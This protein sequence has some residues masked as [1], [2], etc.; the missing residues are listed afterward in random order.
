MADAKRIESNE[1]PGFGEEVH[2]EQAGTIHE[3]VPVLSPEEEHKLYRKIDRRYGLLFCRTDCKS[4]LI[5]CI[6]AFFPFFR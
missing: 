5:P 1:K 3:D 2:L 6:T 4:M